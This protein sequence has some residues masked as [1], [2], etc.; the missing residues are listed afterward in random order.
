VAIVYAAKSENDPTWKIGQTTVKESRLNAHRT[1]NPSL[2][3]YKLQETSSPTKIEKFIHDFLG[4]K[5]V[6]FSGKRR[7]WF[8]A[9]DQ[10]IDVAF[11]AAVDYQDNVLPL[12][13]QVDKLKT[14]TSV[15][16]F[17]LADA[18]TRQKHERL[19]KIE[20]DLSSLGYERE[21]LMLELMVQIGDHKGIEGLISWK[22]HPVQ[23]FDTA[24][25]KKDCPD[26][27]AKYRDKITIKRLFK[28]L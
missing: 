25:F 18:S 27:Y 20:E 19:K 1:S 8:A 7:E 15:G 21:H 28:L 12:Q 26:L 13:K 14:K 6:S 4:S 9:T 23:N 11:A 3:F 10:E 5:R 16:E 22:S 17:L 2:E 24:R